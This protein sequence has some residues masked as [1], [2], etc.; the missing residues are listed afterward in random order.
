M[1]S[2][3]SHT[4]RHGGDTNKDTLAADIDL[5]IYDP[6]GNYV[7][8]SFSWDNNYE[9]VEFTAPVSGDYRAWINDYRFD[10]SYEYLGVAWSRRPTYTISGSVTQ[11]DDSIQH[12]FI[13]PDGT[14]DLKVTLGMPSGTDFD[15]SVWDNLNRRT[16]GWTSAEWYTRTDIPNSVYSNY[17]ADPEWVWVS[18]PDTTGTWKTGTFAWYGNGI[19]TIT[20]ETA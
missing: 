2:W 6:N 5:V 12:G 11:G 10:E 14:G 20:V 19:Y 13:V 15:L 1:I 3:D 8:G 7:G 16:G 17:W 9:V 18:P 4:N